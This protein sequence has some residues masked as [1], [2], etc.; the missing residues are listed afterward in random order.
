MPTAPENGRLRV[1]T[2]VA[3]LGSGGGG[4]EK[5]ARQIAVRLDPAR[6]ERTLCVSRWPPKEGITPDTERVL[7]EL[8]AADLSLVG[9]PRR[10]RG[11]VG[12]WRP[13]MRMLRP[14]H[15]DVLHSHQYGSNGWGAVLSRI[16]RTPV[17]VAHEHSWSFE[18]DPLRR[19]VD[20]EIVARRADAFVAVSNADRRRMIEVEG[21]DAAKVVVIPNGITTPPALAGRDLRGE[22]GI[23][24][25]A[26][27]IGTVSVLRAEKALPVLIRAAAL[28]RERFGGLRVVIAGEGP[29]RGH[30][31]HLI[32]S[33]GLG[34]TVSLLGRRLDIPDL[35]RVMD[36]AVCCSEFE[37]CPLS[38]LEYME[39]GLPVVATRVGGLPELVDDRGNGLLVERDRPDALAAALSELLADPALGAAMGERGRE[40][41][42]A[43]FG[44]ELMVRRV[45]QLYER[46]A[47]ERGVAPAT[48]PQA[49]GPLATPS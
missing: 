19:F 41:R 16:A 18:G 23:E 2:L 5:L 14:A 1:L 10:S 17:V 22:L 21:I 33:L 6:F 30:L 36:V 9:L 45:E 39:A 49:R 32:G 42:R 47:A 24:P 26:P 31:E 7:D 46:L 12:A 27:V 3:G 25:G 35:L 34:E 15:T 13:L 40:R 8:R 11:Q 43:H 28:L 29:E 38:V 4:A 48:Q 37:G 20:R 44:I